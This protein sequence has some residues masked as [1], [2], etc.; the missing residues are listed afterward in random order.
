MGLNTLVKKQI[1]NPSISSGFQQKRE[2][3]IQNAVELATTADKVLG[4]LKDEPIEVQLTEDVCLQFY[5]PTDEQYIDLL[6]IQGEGSQIAVKMQKLGL[7]TSTTDEE[8]EEVIPQA[9]GIINQARDMLMSINEI[10]S[11][12]SVDPSWT[13]EKFK[14]LPKQYKSIIVAAIS[15]TQEKELKKIRKFRKQ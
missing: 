9:L 8:A 15:S 12:L 7:N 4:L 13:P 3:K 14:Q 10:L 2:E 11:V 5:P 6:S 1:E